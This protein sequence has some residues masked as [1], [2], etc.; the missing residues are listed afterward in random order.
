MV[1][2]AT[3]SAVAGRVLPFHRLAVLAG[4][5]ANVGIDRVSWTCTTIDT[6]LFG[7]RIEEF[8]SVGAE[9]TVADLQSD[10]II[11]KYRE[12]RCFTR[13]RCTGRSS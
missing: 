6:S 2:P 7:D 12:K 5:F 13:G 4:I 10:A 1:Q 11:K 3:V 8:A 9:P